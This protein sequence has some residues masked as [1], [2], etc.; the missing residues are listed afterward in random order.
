MGDPVRATGR[1]TL[2]GEA[3][4]ED[5]TLSLAR[6]WGADAIRD[7]DGTQLS[8]E[9]LAGGYRIY[10]TLCLVRAD[11]DWART[12]REHLQQKY[13]MS[14]PRPAT[15]RRLE[16]DLLSGWFRQQFEIDTAHD[17]YRWWEVIDRTTGQVVAAGCWRFEAES[18]TVVVEPAEAWHVYTVSFLVYQVWDPVSMYNHLTNNWTCEHVMGVDPRHG[19]TRRHLIEH[20]DR[21]LPDH[22]DTDVVRLTSLAYNFT[23]NFGDD[24]KKRYVDWCGYHDCTSVAVLEAFEEEMGY[25]LRP[26]AFVDEGYYNNLSRIPSKEYRDWMAFQQRF[27]ADFGREVVEHVHRA[28]KK[29]ILFFCDHW[30]GTEPFGPHFA[31]MGLDGLV[32]PV[33][34]GTQARRIAAVPGDLTKEIRLYPYFFPVDLGGKPVFREGGDP[35]RDS[36]RDWMK[37]RR[38]LLRD[39]VD[40]IGYGGYLSLTLDR[41]DFLNHVGD[42]AG[43]FRQIHARARG[44]A[45]AA[46]PFQVAIL[47]AWGA[48]RSWINEEWEGGGLMESLSG[49][50]FEVEFLSFDDLQ[51]GRIPPEVGVIVNTGSAGTSWSGGRYWAGPAAVRVRQWVAGGGGFLGVGEP[52]AHRHQGRFFQLADVLG[53]ERE[54]G[55][56]KNF[57]RPVGRT[58]ADHFIVADLAGR[59]SLAT[60]ATNVYP[61]SPGTQVLAA[62]GAGVLIA[63]NS[64]GRGRAV[65]LAGYTFSPANTRLLL[66]A[67]YWAARRED[68][69]LNWFCTNVHTECAAYPATG[70]FCVINNSG[71]R[72]ATTVFRGPELSMQVE[73][74]AYEGKWFRIDEMAAG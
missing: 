49:L 50:C 17:P 42:L 58:G 19:A 74:A 34:W 37:V 43:E 70:W 67:L 39:C 16:I 28:G 31:E 66:R 3:G 13:L 45:P 21:W 35:V 7:S 8:P 60:V 72:Q 2:P 69:L 11:Q 5:A 40:R 18:G 56:T 65:Y 36:L 61:T 14:D 10:S 44:T 57:T 32:N 54:V 22:P 46:A 6:R 4:K 68:D 73:L 30:I 59:P 51:A 38:A 33:D 71:D 48:I 64:F 20:L 53:V 24:A 29:A 47:N 15:G 62:D 1:F 41:P 23:F 55:L 63:A 52:T 27:V 9:I 25:R 12:H 26:E